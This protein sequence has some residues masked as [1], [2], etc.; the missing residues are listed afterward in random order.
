MVV[1]KILEIRTS[2]YLCCNCNT[3][4][5]HRSCMRRVYVGVY[6]CIWLL[7]GRVYVDI[8]RY[9]DCFYTCCSIRAML[10]DI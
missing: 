6:T 2:P 7:L 9:M 4:I 3:L 8:M 5:R 1:A 10:I